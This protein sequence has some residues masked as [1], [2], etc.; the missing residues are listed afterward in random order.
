MVSKLQELKWKLKRMRAL[1]K[2]PGCKARRLRLHWPVREI[3]PSSPRSHSRQS[4]FRP[5]LKSNLRYSRDE[6]EAAIIRQPACRPARRP[7]FHTRSTSRWCE[8]HSSFQ[9]ICGGHNKMEA[10][11]DL[12]VFMRGIFGLH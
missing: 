4:E 8:G 7:W 5:A 6:S 12:Q 1:S 11:P 9:D 10:F 3:D 2:A